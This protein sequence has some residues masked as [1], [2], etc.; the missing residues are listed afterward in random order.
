MKRHLDTSSSKS[1]SPDLKEIP[2]PGA[3][4][5]RCTRDM[6]AGGLTRTARSCPLCVRTSRG[7]QR[8]RREAAI[9]APSAKNCFNQNHLAF[10]PEWSILREKQLLIDFLANA[11]GGTVYDTGRDMK[12]A[13]KG[14]RI[15]EEDCQHLMAHPSATLESFNLSEQEKGKVLAFI[16][17]TKADIVE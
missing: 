14:M 16:E 17:S 9:S 2:T 5:T 7:N 13:H 6:P 10:G 11:A 12:T 1:R 3:S 8:S 15:D 4:D